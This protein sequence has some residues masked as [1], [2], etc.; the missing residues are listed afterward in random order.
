MNSNTKNKLNIV[1]IG[2]GT[3]NF[4]VLS[5]LKSIKNTSITAIV[6]STDS[7]GSTGR[8]RD[9][10]GLLP[11]GDI[12]QCLIAL[13]QN[14]KN[15][16]ILRKLFNYRFDRGED[17]LKG[18]NFG[19]L[20]LTVLTDILGSE[21]QAIEITRQLLKIKGYVYPVTLQKCNLCAE[22]ENGK[23]IVGEHNIDEPSYPHDGRLKITKVF[24]D[25][26]VET[27]N[28]VKTK[29]KNADVIIIGPGDL[30]TS[31]IANLI[32]KD[33][34]ESISLSKA[35]IIYI[36]NLMT[37][38]AQTYN[39]TAKDHVHEIEK[40]LG[41]KVDFVLINNSKIPQN[42]LDKYRLQND[43]E[44][45]DDLGN[46]NRVIRTDLLA[47]EQT[48][49]QKGDVLKRSLIRHDSN[50]IKKTILEIFIKYLNFNFDKTEFNN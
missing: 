16:E 41:K 48:N 3:G 35:K 8:L 21:L 4:V 40:Y 5:A 10:F 18:H 26:V 25:T 47:S 20:F 30:Y 33:I 49:T 9:E 38:Y 39:Y 46:D 23:I 45:R 42:L 22:Y 29:I 24:T 12:R 11:V 43:E 37:K 32:I 19:N 13:S 7:G 28:K 15:Q 50:K 1:V 27:Y 2:G 6:P 34:P 31:L 14:K 44:V 36:V 17:G